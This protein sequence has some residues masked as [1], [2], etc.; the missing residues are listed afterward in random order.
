[1]R[2]GSVA[3]RADAAET[4]LCTYFSAVVLLGLAANA[5]Y[6]WRWMVPWRGLWSPG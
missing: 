4:L 5:L 2:L 3:L 6:G 1:M